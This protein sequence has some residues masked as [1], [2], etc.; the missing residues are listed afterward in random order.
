MFIERLIMF[1]W[2]VCLKYG[3]LISYTPANTAK[4]TKQRI[5]EITPPQ[6]WWCESYQS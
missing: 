1:L 5:V 2:Y 6:T 3:E 4:K